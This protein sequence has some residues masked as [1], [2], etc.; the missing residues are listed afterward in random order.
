MDFEVVG[1]D[2]FANG[3]A[4]K[5]GFYLFLDVFGIARG[6]ERC[7]GFSRAIA[8]QAGLFLKFLGNSVP[9]CADTV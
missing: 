4:D 5:F 7:G 2:G 9:F 1:F 8:G 6:D 3:L